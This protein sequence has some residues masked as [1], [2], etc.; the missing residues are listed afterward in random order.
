MTYSFSLNA[1]RTE[2]QHVRASMVPE[3]II[4]S[5]PSAALLTPPETGASTN[6]KSLLCKRLSSW[7]T[8]AGDTVD[9]RIIDAPDGRAGTAP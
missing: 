7:L 5:V 6:F 9:E 4:V 8:N 1:L 3:A 2:P